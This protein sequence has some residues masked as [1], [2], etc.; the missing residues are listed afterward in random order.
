MEFFTTDLNGLTLINPE[1]E[2]RR[3]ILESVLQDPDADYPE[4]YLTTD[5][6]IV[7]GYRTGG[8]LFQEEDGEITRLIA[9]CSLDAAEKVWTALATGREEALDELPWTYLED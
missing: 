9:D 1:R 8:V 3:H 5:V 4:V 7:I 6:G 2:D